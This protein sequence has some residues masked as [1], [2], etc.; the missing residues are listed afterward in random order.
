MCFD[1]GNELIRGMSICINPVSG[2]VVITSG[3]NTTSGAFHIFSGIILFIWGFFRKSP[4]G[5]S[6]RLLYNIRELRVAA[7]T[8]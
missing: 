3:V 7:V 6:T 8:Q 5:F 4:G 2:K 1:R